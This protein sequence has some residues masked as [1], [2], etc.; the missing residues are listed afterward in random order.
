LDLLAKHIKEHGS[1][2]SKGTISIAD[3][4]GLV[5]VILGK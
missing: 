4:T 5:N 2:F 1:S 3:V